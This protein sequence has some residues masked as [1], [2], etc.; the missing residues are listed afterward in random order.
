[1]GA[2]ESKALWAQR[3]IPACLL[4]PDTAELRLKL[5]PSMELEKQTSR[6]ILAGSQPGA[7]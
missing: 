2:R 3:E 6:M 7:R 1:M 4:H 5:C